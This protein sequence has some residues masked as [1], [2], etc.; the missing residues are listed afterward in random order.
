MGRETLL[1]HFYSQDIR[2]YKLSS[3][4]TDPLHIEVSC[5][6]PD[7]QVTTYRTSP[8]HAGNTNDVGYL[9]LS[10]EEVCPSQKQFAGSYR[11]EAINATR[12]KKN[13][14]EILYGVE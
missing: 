5:H 6:K 13:C 9:L 4:L 12:N 14:P 10:P 1:I 3:L 8:H 11:A 7:I 2:S